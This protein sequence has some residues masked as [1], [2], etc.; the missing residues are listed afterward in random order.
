MTFNVNGLFYD[1]WYQEKRKRESFGDL[2]EGHDMTGL[3]LST[4]N[5]LKTSTTITTMDNLN[6]LVEKT[7]I[8]FIVNAP[9]FFST[10]QKVVQFHLK[11]R[12]DYQV[13]ELKKK[14]FVR[15]SWSFGKY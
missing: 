7:N 4:F 6:D 13:H 3:K 14:T 5:Q 10:C 15:L 8:Y 11:R 2:L 1:S 12:I 9:L